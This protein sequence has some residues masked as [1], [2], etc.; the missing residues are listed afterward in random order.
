MR[1]L[2]QERAEFGV[3]PLRTA[4][5]QESQRLNPSFKNTR[6]QTGW[7]AHTQIDRYHTLTHSH[8]HTPLTRSRNCSCPACPARPGPVSGG[9]W[10]ARCPG[11]R[12]RPRPRGAPHTASHARRPPPPVS[13]EGA[14]LERLASLAAA[15]KRCARLG[16]GV[17][18]WGIGH[19]TF[20]RAAPARCVPAARSSS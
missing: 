7:P 4:M 9:A 12:S 19:A 1:Q 15:R 8:T 18:G 16:H 13:G 3:E 6:A 5:E 10:R 20:A 14:G 11:R 17:E 2:E